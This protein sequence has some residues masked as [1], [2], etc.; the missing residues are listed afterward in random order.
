VYL[1]QNSLQAHAR[2]VLASCLHRP[3]R[4]AAQYYGY[5]AIMLRLTSRFI[6]IAVFIM[7]IAAGGLF[8]LLWASLPARDAVYVERG[9]RSSVDVEFDVHG[10]PSIYSATREDAYRALGFVTAQD[11]LF[12]M[13]LLRR[14]G[15]GRLAEI[16]GAPLLK[17]DL[18]HRTMGFEQI[19]LAILT[20]LPE[21]QKIILKGYAEGVNQALAQAKIL[22]F[23]FLALGYQPEPW[24][25]QDSLLVVL[26]MFEQM[27]WW[28][29]E[30][31]R[32]ATVMD[33]A[34]GPEVLDFLTP[35]TDRYTDSVIGIPDARRPPQAIPTQALSALL[36]KST[37]YPNGLAIVPNIVS[38][39]NG[40]VVGSAKTSDGRAILANDMHLNLRVPNIWYRAQMHIMGAFTA[41]ITL[42][43]VPM[44]ISGAN[45]H[46]AWGFTNVAGDFLDFILLD[47]DEKNQDVYQTP[48]GKA[49]F[50]HRSEKIHVKGKPDETF[51][52]RTTIW[53]PVMADTLLGKPV[54]VHWTALDPGATNLNLLRLSDTENVYDALSVLQNAGG[55]PLNGLV[56]DVKGNIGWTYVGKIP[57][58][59]G[60]NGLVS[61]SWADGSRGWQ[62]YV[63][64]DDKPRII[65]PAQG[66]VVNAN[67]R[68]VGQDYPYVIGQDFDSGYRAFRISEQ[69]AA[70]D[71]VNEM[72]L[73]K[74]QLD[75]QTDFYR[76]YQILALSLLDGKVE[77][78]E[79]LDLGSLRHY[80]QAWDGHAEPDSV[81][82][83]VLVEFR[84]ILTDAIFSPF[85][86]QC[87][88]LD[89]DFKYDW[90]NMDEP[91]KALLE[92]R[93]VEFQPEKSRYPDWNAFLLAKLREAVDA[94]LATCGVS[95]LDRVTWSCV[96]KAHI[97]HPFSALSPLLGAWLDMPIESIP[98]C[99]HCVRAAAGKNGASERMVVAPG[100]EK[101]SIFQM[102]AGQSGNPM[103]EFYRDQHKN[104]VNGAASVFLGGK[105]KY[106]LKFRPAQSK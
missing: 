92:A 80:L 42:P 89:P 70:M 20:Q 98:G 84:R 52:V 62:G 74:M 6:L 45:H 8:L 18:W 105:R 14:R 5:G 71:K 27:T 72:D 41:G 28:I 19:A 30:K 39:S 87:Q 15:A 95:S 51:D 82:L 35:D 29:G 2:K 25:E 65:N 78:Y 31:E 93:E 57:K 53:G 16:L 32:M 77:T 11:R 46:I 86:A 34:L 96:N 102:P 103:S 55:P 38:G 106:L 26:G 3:G 36:A 37:E 69:L 68:M 4:L 100:H 12:Q 79:G 94:A 17:S 58:R 90:R 7:A 40:W 54:A 13:D 43:G 33:H 88:K 64:D 83:P 81:G 97:E 59:I 61:H 63:A 73:L 99:T 101:N 48:T 75:T 50:E 10:V 60:L 104:W 76:Y 22:P 91:L 49:Q 21:E 47:M 1:R 56:A 67:Q 85:L 66:Y 24:R 44:F 9:F 23:E